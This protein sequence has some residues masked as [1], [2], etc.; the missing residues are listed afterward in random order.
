[1]RRGLC[2]ATCLVSFPAMPV[3]T[4]AVPTSLPVIVLRPARVFDSEEEAF[5]A[6]QSGRIAVGDVIV[7]RYEGP[8]GGP[9]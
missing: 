9:S 7:I 2:I 8:K 3:V 5:A 1:M 6:V 4:A